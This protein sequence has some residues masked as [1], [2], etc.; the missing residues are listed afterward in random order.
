MYRLGKKRIAYR[1]D[2]C[3]TCQAERIAEQ[4]RTFDVIHVLFVPVLP[5]EFETHWHCVVCGENPHERTRTSKIMKI[6]AAALLALFLAALWS[7]P[8]TGADA[9]GLWT[10]RITAPRA[11]AGLL[12]SLRDSAGSISLQEGLKS[13]R[14]LPSDFCLYCGAVLESDGFCRRCQV[15]HDSLNRSR[16]LVRGEMR[17]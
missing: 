15:R 10:L 3:L 17:R 2:F 9:A 16:P 8:A 5:L 6:A 1:N 4:Y 7:F 11:L 13:V 12:V 14:P